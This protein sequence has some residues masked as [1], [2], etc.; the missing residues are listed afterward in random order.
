MSATEGGTCPSK[1]TDKP[2]HL[3]Q[4]GASNHDRAEPIRD[5]SLDLTYYL[6]MSTTL[7][8]SAQVIT[9]DSPD[10]TLSSSSVEG[11]RSSPNK[12]GFWW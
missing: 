5:I 7:D 6:Q 2:A 11:F 8:A 1:K 3:D 12:R 9:K 4:D 10:W